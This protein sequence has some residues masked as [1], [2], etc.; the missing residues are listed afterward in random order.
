MNEN[1]T[2]QGLREPAGITVTEVQGGRGKASTDSMA[3]C[4]QSTTLVHGNMVAEEAEPGMA[5]HH[6]ELP[7]KLP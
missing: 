6:A 7:T 5:V 3:P 4:E 2:A 1:K